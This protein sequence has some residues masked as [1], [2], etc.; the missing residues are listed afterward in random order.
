VVKSENAKGK[1]Q[2]NLNGNSPLRIIHW[3]WY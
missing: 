2:L 3:F 1:V